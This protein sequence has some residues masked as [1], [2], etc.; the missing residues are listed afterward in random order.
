MSGAA[1]F[2][3]VAGEIQGIAE[4][5]S[6]I[7]GDLDTKIYRLLEAIGIKTVAYLRSFTGQTRPPIRGGNAPR[8]AHPGGWADVSG[9]LAASYGYIV[10]RTS[11]T[12]GWRLVLMNGA[13]YAAALEARDAFYVLSGVTDRGGP[14]ET[15]L[16]EAVQ[17]VAPDWVVE[18]YD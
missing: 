10:A 9:Q 17:E 13:E 5:L 12:G 7:E 14:V 11:L 2:M 8:P 3:V 1:G 16:R 6:T 4:T 18:S 15:A